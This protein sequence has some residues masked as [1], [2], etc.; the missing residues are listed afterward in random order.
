[1]SQTLQGLFGQILRRRREEAE[2]TQERLGHQAGLS[3]NFI[4]MLE[5]GE[6]VPTIITIQQLARALK[7]TMSALIQELEQSVA[8]QAHSAGES[9][10][11]G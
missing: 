6:R 1:M 4:G 9:A 11:D 8:S 5:R 2:M 10:D 3:R 7:T